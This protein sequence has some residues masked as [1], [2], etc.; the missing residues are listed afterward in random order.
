MA[1]IDEQRQEKAIVVVQKLLLGVQA[2]QVEQD[3][4]AP[5]PSEAAQVGQLAGRP[6]YI[7]E[8]NASH[9]Q[10]TN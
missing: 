9:S 2:V 8:E 5:L 6:L 4:R 3:H 7:P 1:R 10:Q